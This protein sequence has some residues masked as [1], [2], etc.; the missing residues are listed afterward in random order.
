MTSIF[1]KPYVYKLCMYAIYTIY[2]YMI[3]MI[4]YINISG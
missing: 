2:I 4:L 3:C 1:Y